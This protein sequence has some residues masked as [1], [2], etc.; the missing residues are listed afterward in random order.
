MALWFFWITLLITLLCVGGL[1]TAIVLNLLLRQVFWMKEFLFILGGAVVIM[2]SQ[3]SIYQPG[4]FSEEIE[5]N[6]YFSLLQIGAILIAWGYLSLMF[7]VH[8]KRSEIAR[9]SLLTGWSVS[10]G[11]SV[12]LKWMGLFYDIFL[13]FPAVSVVIPSVYII[14]RMNIFKRKEFGPMLVLLAAVSLA[15]YVFEIIEFLLQTANIS[16]I[17]HI[18]SGSFAFTGFSLVLAVTALVFCL[19]N[20]RA[21][22][23]QMTGSVPSENQINVFCRTNELTKRES[24]IVE[25]LILR[26]THKE[27]ADQ[28]NISSR[29]V[30]RHVYNMYQKT[31]LSNRFEL[32]DLIRSK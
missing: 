11:I 2:I 3:L 28:L 12:L 31:G 15:G 25:K 24:E 5:G 1:T 16:F 9:F 19:K 7:I 8:D 32:Y 21:L 20:V 4:I 17:E 13:Y 18:P 27:I 30:E 6:L 26:F 29:T 23:G 22:K 10:I 14:I